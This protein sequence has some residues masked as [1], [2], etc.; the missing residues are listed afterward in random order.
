MGDE[1]DRPYAILVVE[2]VD[3]LREFI[4]ETLGEFGENFSVIAAADGVAALELIEDRDEPFDLVV[5]DITMPRLDGESL[6]RDLRARDYPAPVIILT[7]HGQDDIIIRCL[8]SGACDYLIKPVDID[9]LLLSVNTA[10]QHGAYAN[11]PVEVEYDPNGWFEMS[12]GSDY[13]VLY[14][15]RKFLSLLSRFQIDAEHEQEVR[16]VLEELGRNA[17]EWG[18]KQDL[19]KRVRFACRVAPGKIMILIEDQGEGY[20]PEAVPDPTLDPIAHV[21]RRQAEGKRL[22]GY[23]IHLVRNLMD[24]VTWNETGNTVMAIK[25]LTKGTGKAEEPSRS[26]AGKASDLRRDD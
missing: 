23:G 20:D 25:Y 15:Y 3:S 22:G 24:K 10:L 2:D 14:R 13:S 8:N 19:E 1:D 6:L 16:L 5:S 4:V 17:I 26:Q 11:L 9:A 21:H 18:N 12:G 7:A